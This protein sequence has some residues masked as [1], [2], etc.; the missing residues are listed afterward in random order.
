M[1]QRNS[2]HCVIVCSTWII[3][4]LMFRLYFEGRKGGGCRNPGKFF[5]RIITLFVLVPQVVISLIVASSVLSELTTFRVLSALIGSV[6]LLHTVQAYHFYT[7]I[8]R[9]ASLFFHTYRSLVSLAYFVFV[10]FCYQWFILS[11]SFIT[12]TFLDEQLWYCFRKSF[13]WHASG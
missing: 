10:Y 5:T 2:W 7:T 1:F 3:S 6:T 8:S 12:G 13:F 11:F 9:N 4:P